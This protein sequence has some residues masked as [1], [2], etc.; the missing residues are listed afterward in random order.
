MGYIGES[1]Y[2]LYEEHCTHN[3]VGED[4][5]VA[6]ADALRVNN[7]LKELHLCNNDITD[8]G[9]RC[10]A[11]ALV[12]NK[13]LKWLCTNY[14]DDEFMERLDQDKR[15][16]IIQRLRINCFCEEDCSDLD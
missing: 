2:E 7:S 3:K 9:L 10:F 1:H 5:A 16:R 8:E 13:A 15:Q 14:R 6:L 4:G 12:E 11:E